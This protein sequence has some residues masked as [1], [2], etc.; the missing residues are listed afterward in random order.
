MSKATKKSLKLPI[1]LI[2]GPAIAVIGSIILYAVVNFLIA[3][4]TTDTASSSL[5]GEQPILKI[6]VNVV[7][8]ILGTG[9]MLAFVPCLV[10]GV[11]ILSKR[12]NRGE[13]ITPTDNNHTE[14]SWKDLE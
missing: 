13:T 2:I 12:R 8:Y 1:F 14:R 10:I 4:A 11:I 7:L 5:F 3:G 6:I 9:G